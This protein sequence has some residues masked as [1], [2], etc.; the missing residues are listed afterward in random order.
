MQTISLKILGGPIPPPPLLASRFLHNETLFVLFV[1][2]LPCEQFQTIS[3]MEM[4]I[5]LP[6]NNK[7]NKNTNNTSSTSG[8]LFS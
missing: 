6:G 5:A 3:M 2:M 4:A 7:N 1:L 8:S